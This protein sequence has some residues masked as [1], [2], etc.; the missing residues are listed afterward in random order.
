MKKMFGALFMAA[1]LIVAL[2]M[3][4]SA[5]ER[6]SDNTFI[7]ARPQGLGGAFVGVAD[8]AS[9]MRYNPG[10]MGYLWLREAT[11][12]FSQNYAGVNNDHINQTYLG[13]VNPI[14]GALV[15]G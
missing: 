8:D 3:N 7:G 1:L 2:W 12:M 6:S 9:G 15:V 13:L 14:P 11:V 4:L 10:G 5:E